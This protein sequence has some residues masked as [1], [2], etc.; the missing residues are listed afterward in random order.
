MHGMTLLHHCTSCQPFRGHMNDVMAC[1][2]VSSKYCTDA[3]P[4][5]VLPLH[6]TYTT[7]Q[8]KNDVIAE[9]PEHHLDSISFMLRQV[10]NSA[11]ARRT[12]KIA[13]FRTDCHQICTVGQSFCE[14]ETQTAM[15]HFQV[16]A[17]TTGD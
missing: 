1:S 10:I 5:L 12:Y 2:T 3:K 15:D 17:R 11:C 9:P 14:L 16:S 6:S 4:M 8:N 7:T 13:C